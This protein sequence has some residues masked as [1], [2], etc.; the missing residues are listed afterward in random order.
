LSAEFVQGDVTPIARPHSTGWRTMPYLVTARLVGGENLLEFE[1][2]PPLT[3]RAGDC[4]VVRAGMR[5]RFTLQSTGEAISEWSHVQFN[6]FAS[7]DI[8]AIIE[9]P[10]VV[11]GDTAQRIG[12][13]NRDLT[14]CRADATLPGAVHRRALLFA[15]L[16]ALLSA[17]PDPT[18]TLEALRQ[19]QR[20]APILTV[21]SERL[22]DA[23]LTIDELAQL[24]GLST[25]RFHALFRS[26]MGQAPARY[27]QGQRMARAEQLLL[28]SELKIRAIAERSG[29]ADEFHFSRLFKQLHG[30]SPS[31]YR[32]QTAA[33]GL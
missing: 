3:Q 11:S 32:E 16:D 27:I 7:I 12:A 13:I 10:L 30:L 28:A 20:L 1:S 33:V 29:W 14:Q 9:P 31:R 17:C 6:A 22:G 19:A 5:H 26:A 4:L 2:R 25:S 18:R 23:E 24:I 21:I 8:L 15:L